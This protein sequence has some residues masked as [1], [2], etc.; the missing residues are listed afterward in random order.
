M[1]GVPVKMT[2]EVDIDDATFANITSTDDW[3]YAIARD[4][5][6]IHYNGNP[7]CGGPRGTFTV[8]TT[9]TGL[10]VKSTVTWKIFGWKSYQII[11]RMPG[12]SVINLNCGGWPGGCAPGGPLLLE[13]NPNEDLPE[14]SASYAKC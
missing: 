3:P 8:N 4:C 1:Y 10:V 6:A 12:D 7:Y 14:E 5:Y 13:L 2:M 9:N 11:D